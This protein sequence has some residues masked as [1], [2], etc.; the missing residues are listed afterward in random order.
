MLWSR[1]GYYLAEAKSIGEAWR[2][3]E[4]NEIN[5]TICQ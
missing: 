4:N 5:N 2:N 3:M 1:S